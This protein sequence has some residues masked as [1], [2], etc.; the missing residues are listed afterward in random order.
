MGVTI[1][2]NGHNS[3]ITLESI[4]TFGGSFRKDTSTK[5]SQIKLLQVA[6]TQIGFNTQGIDGIFGNN[7]RAA[8]QSFQRAHNLKADGYFG[9]DSLHILE[10]LLVN[11]LD[12]LNCTSLSSTLEFTD[13]VNNHHSIS[14]YKIMTAKRVREFD[15]SVQKIIQQTKSD[16]QLS[17]ADYLANLNE[18]ASDATNTYD[19]MDCSGYLLTARQGYGYHGSTT[20]FCKHCYVFGSVSD[21][22]GYDHLV[23]GMELY[24]ACRYS[25]NSMLYYA[26]HIG[27]YAGL[28]TFADGY[29]A[30]AV[31]QSSADFGH[32]TVRYHKE[33]GCNGKQNGS[34]LSTLS[35]A[36][37]YWGWSKYVSL[38]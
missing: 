8:V 32:L 34:N 18:L 4:H 24:Q 31:Y 30:H 20:N 19:V 2:G 17:V 37:T 23:P 6:L 27:V 28:I 36:W 9:R 1:N 10:K 33:K 26:S 22:G 11:H 5:H 21:L 15:T 7:T 35:S 25:Q 3:K 16:F 14:K 29:Q 13:S 12:P 38:P